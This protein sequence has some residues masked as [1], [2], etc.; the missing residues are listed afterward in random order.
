VVLHP[1]GC[2]TSQWILLVKFDTG[3]VEKFSQ[4]MNKGIFTMMRILCGNV[5]PH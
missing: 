1:E 3:R 5:A 4:F 2:Q